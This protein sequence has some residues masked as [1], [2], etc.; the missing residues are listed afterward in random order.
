MYTKLALAVLIASTAAYAAHGQPIPEDVQC[1]VFDDGYTNVE[2]PSQAI[3]ISGH[4]RPD[5]RGEACIPDGEFG[6]CHKWFGRCT[7]TKTSQPVY[8]YVFDDGGKNMSGPSDAIYVPR[9]GN[10]ACVPDGSPS[11]TCRRWFG[12][13]TLSNRQPVYC[14]VF[15]DGG[16]NRSLP[17]TAIYIPRPIP[18]AGSA[19]I[20]DETAS[21]TCRRWFGGCFTGV[22]FQ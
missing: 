12:Q 20:P 19:C 4:A 6:R 2:G 21:G 10:Q 18:A 13:G 1:F 17:S 7:T 16:A 8:F 14:S 3:Y 22:V 11:G 5:E 9:E 15:D